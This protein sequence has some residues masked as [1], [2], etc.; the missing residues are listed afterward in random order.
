[1]ASHGLTRLAARRSSGRRQPAIRSW[2]GGVRSGWTRAGGSPRCAPHLGR[3]MPSASLR[4]RRGP[5]PVAKVC[6][7]SRGY[8]LGTPFSADA[9]KD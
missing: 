6:W 5:E 4:G 3:L 9:E 7:G 2:R 8:P 1:M